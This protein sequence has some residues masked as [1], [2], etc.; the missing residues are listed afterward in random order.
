MRALVG[1]VDFAS[2][3][4]MAAF[5]VSLSLASLFDTFAVGVERLMEGG[6]GG[7]GAVCAAGGGGGRVDEEEEEE[8]EEEGGRFIRGLDSDAR[9]RIWGTILAGITE[10]VWVGG[11]KGCPLI[12]EGSS[13]FNNDSGTQVERGWRGRRTRKGR[14]GR[15]KGLWGA[16]MTLGSI[17][18]WV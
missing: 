16:G 3:S 13:H 18:M 9:Q 6:E 8:E 11:G 1:H 14:G 10:L 4:W 2:E 7:A 12:V 17:G 5:N 15:R